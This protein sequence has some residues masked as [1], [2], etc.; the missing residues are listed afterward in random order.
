MN[1]LWLI[2][3]R[4]MCLTKRV[5]TGPTLRESI[6]KNYLSLKKRLSKTKQMQ[7]IIFKEKEFL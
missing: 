1:N 7:F 6:K 4:L 2:E 5:I 3:V